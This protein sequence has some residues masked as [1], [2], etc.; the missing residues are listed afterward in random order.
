MI[1][2][3]TKNK[4]SRAYELKQLI[5]NDSEDL[6]IL[7]APIYYGALSGETKV[8]LESFYDQGALNKRIILVLFSDQI[9]Q[10]GIAVMEMLPWCYKHQVTLIHVECI[11]KQTD[12]KKAA[13]NIQ[14]KVGVTGEM[15]LEFETLNYLDQSAEV[16]IT[17]K[18]RCEHEDKSK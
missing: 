15:F 6:M 7:M 2:I 14:S 11:H 10:E 5:R 9:N 3:T 13:T 16:P 18:L 12:L 1:I 4:Q 17:Y 8:Y